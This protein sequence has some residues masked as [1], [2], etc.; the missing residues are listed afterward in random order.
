MAYVTKSGYIK[1]RKSDVTAGV[2]SGLVDATAQAAISGVANHIE[3]NR[4]RKIS[5]GYTELASDME[6][7][8]KEIRN[9]SDIEDYHSKY[10]EV[11]QE[12]LA[13][14]DSM[15]YSAGIKKA[16]KQQF[17]SKAQ[18]FKGK[19]SLAVV[20]DTETLANENFDA[21]IKDVLEQDIDYLL[22]THGYEFAD[23]EPKEPNISTHSS[24]GSGVMDFSGIPQEQQDIKRLPVQKGASAY[25]IRVAMANE[26]L[27]Q[28]FGDDTGT[29]NR[30]MD[31]L[32]PMIRQAQAK[33]DS[34]LRFD[35]YYDLNNQNNWNDAEFYSK[36]I[37]RISNSEY[38]GVRLTYPEQKDLEN[39]VVGRYDKHKKEMG[40]LA[41][42]WYNSTV[43]P[44]MMEWDNQKR[45]DP[46][47]YVTLDKI[48][49]L[50][51]TSPVP[52]E[53]T[54]PYISKLIT[55]GE[56]EVHAQKL[57]E[58]G[59]LS[60]IK[61]PTPEEQERLRNLGLRLSLSDKAYAINKYASD[62]AVLE[63]NQWLKDGEE[64]L[65]LAN[66]ISLREAG[67]LHEDIEVAGF[68]VPDV[69]FFFTVGREIEKH[70]PEGG[71]TT[72]LDLNNY[73]YN[74]AKDMFAELEVPL[75]RLP[76]LK[77][78]ID[79]RTEDMDSYL[80]NKATGHRKVSVPYV[81]YELYTAMF[82]EDQK[83]FDNLLE[84]Y[85]TALSQEDYNE[86]RKIDVMDLTPKQRQLKSGVDLLNEYFSD[87]YSRTEDGKIPAIL[88]DRSLGQVRAAFIRD[89]S[90]ELDRNPN[91]DTSSFVSGF[92]T[93]AVDKVL[94]DTQSNFMDFIRGDSLEFTKKNFLGVMSATNSSSIFADLST[95]EHL[96]VDENDLSFILSDNEFASG[97]F[98]IDT[99]LM[100]HLNSMLEA[101]RSNKEIGDTIVYA[102]GRHFGLTD[103]DVGWNFDTISKKNTKELGKVLEPL[104]PVVQSQVMQTSSII[105]YMV[106]TQR[107][108]QVDLDP[109]LLQHLTRDGTQM[110]SAYESGALTVTIGDTHLSYDPSRES[111]SYLNGNKINTI[112]VLNSDIL[113][114]ENAI[115]RELFNR[116]DGIIDV[117]NTTLQNMQGEPDDKIIDGIVDSLQNIVISSEG[118]K[119]VQQQSMVY[120]NLSN[121]RVDE[122][123]DLT[124]GKKEKYSAIEFYVDRNAIETAIK[125]KKI[126]QADIRQFIK[127]R[128]LTGTGYTEVDAISSAAMS[129]LRR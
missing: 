102:V 58:F 14:I 8:F 79:T 112:T 96:F 77:K 72:V 53:Y 86:F 90:A 47:F 91:V 82:N 128:M 115:Q 7:R 97:I 103:Y 57:E 84:G 100:G 94:F 33:A 27:D 114:S 43:L 50:I 105:K 13:A 31:N 41:E 118:D 48:Y 64:A 1:S 78:T 3:T 87:M 6:A 117:I 75:S 109:E 83:G 39:H 24:L 124:N 126:G 127:M 80:K 93:T 68:W 17:T 70:D 113:Q 92:Y 89:F 106:D 121:I 34:D 10:D 52:L 59:R 110:T 123:N 98:G 104:P 111:F 54:M 18:E 108:A 107:K 73:A 95:S 101:G 36:E 9:T 20:Q 25:D 85:R 125:T 49:D 30:L 119:K 29:K 63:E 42:G 26:F 61:D 11:I 32:I 44:Q 21:N 12:K 69:D 67:Y 45:D 122:Y 5:D 76:E 129:N 15:E 19:V 55:L 56:N 65:Q 116:A 16:I 99:N 51:Y 81:K 40:L 60:S 71:K 38:G 2:V 4:Q 37:E 120:L 74:K 62:M 23:Y 88:R 66:Y 35:I 22:E 46:S 28:R